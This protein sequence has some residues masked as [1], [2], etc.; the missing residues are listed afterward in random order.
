MYLKTN[1]TL[2]NG[3]YMI[4]N[5]LDHSE[6]EF[7][8]SG[9]DL[10]I[11][12]GICIKEFFIS[13]LCHRDDYSSM[14]TTM[15]E[16]DQVTI[17][18]Y[19]QKY[20]QAL[21]TISNFKHPNIIK[22]YD[23]FEENGTVYSVTELLEGGSLREYVVAHGAMDENTALVC[24]RQVCDVLAYIHQYK[25]LH[26]NINPENI[27]LRK[28]EY[29]DVVVIDFHFS[30]LFNDFGTQTGSD[31]TN[32]KPFEQYGQSGT[33]QLSPA[34]DIYSL[35]AT[36][37]Y[38]L[39]GV[40]P[41]DAN[42]I[43]LTGIPELPNHVS[44]NTRMAIRSAMS[45]NIQDR[46]QSINIFIKFWSFDMRGTKMM[47]EKG[48]DNLIDN[49]W[50]WFF[51]LFFPT[52]LYLAGVRSKKKFFFS[53]LLHPAFLTSVYLLIINIIKNNSVDYIY[54]SHLDD[55]TYYMLFS[56]EILFIIG[57]V[58]GY[59]AIQKPIQQAQL[60]SGIPLGLLIC[61]LFSFGFGY[62]IFTILIFIVSLIIIVYNNLTKN[63][64]DKK[65]I[66]KGSPVTMY[67]ILGLTVLVSTFIMMFFFIIVLFDS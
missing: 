7:T 27:I 38:L 41:P 53:F 57:S 55:I 32:Y 21:Q 18:K 51:W 47:S 66:I 28:K 58:I 24:I 40:R 19:K 62:Y 23:F 45:V 22:I 33:N 20:I 60:S 35:G 13:S 6:S 49:K 34:T 52:I 4:Q 29:I 46:P 59:F 25:I 2:Q 15:S 36:L 10:R 16:Y 14:V 3:R 65:Q 54:T 50:R 9:Y 17:E 63:N 37:Y 8:Y 61:S 42:S 67:F 11:G 48:T 5:V 30:K 39:A 56:I 64:W 26:L 12:R 31:A 1:C 44:T 43:L